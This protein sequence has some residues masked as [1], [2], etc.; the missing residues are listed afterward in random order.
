MEA[1]DHDTDIKP[2]T[3]GE[4]AVINLDRRQQR[5]EAR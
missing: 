2:A 4:I 5:G 3:D 1:L